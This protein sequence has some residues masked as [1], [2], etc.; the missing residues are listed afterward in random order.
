[1]ITNKVKD[2]LRE[3]LQT[4]ILLVIIILNICLNIPEIVKNAFVDASVPISDLQVLWR[5][6][7][8]SGRWIFALA[9]LGVAYLFI[10]KSNKDYVLK[11]NVSNKIVWHTYAGY[12]YCRY[13]LNIKTLSLT[14]VPIPMQFK[15]IWNNLFDS[16][17]CLDGVTEKELGTDTVKVEVFQDNPITSTINL[18]LADTYPLDWRSK[19][20]ASVLSLTTIAIDRVGDKGVRYYSPDYVAKIASTVHELPNNVVEIN[21]FATINAANCYHIAKEVFMTGGRDNLKHLRIYEQTEGSWVFEGNHLQI[22]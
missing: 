20:P 7:I 12:K 6:A 14:R 21:I 10:R 11:Q 17:E 1:M 22:Y 13:I 9:V 4:A 8:G 15:L 19:L 5:F 2:W 16:Y 3:Y 18:V